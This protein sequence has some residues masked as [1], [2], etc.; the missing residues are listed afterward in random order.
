M[1]KHPLIHS[2][3]PPL[4]VTSCGANPDLRLKAAELAEILQVKAVS[5]ANT[6]IPGLLLIYTEKGL[7]IQLKE[8]KIDG[9]LTVDF[10]SGAQTYRRLRGGGIKQ[11][12]AKAVGIKPGIR[13]SVFDATAGLGGDAFCLACLGCRVTMNERSPILS[14][15]LE[16]GLQRA[17]NDPQLNAQLA[18][19]LTLQRGDSR[20]IITTTRTGIDTIYMDPMYPHRQKSALN[21]QQM[22]IIRTLVG[23]D[24][25]ADELLQTSLRYAGKRVVV[26][27]PKGAGHLADLSPS[28]CITMKNSRYDVYMIN[29]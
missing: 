2:D 25:D 24:M 6:Q 12:L 19:R 21:K 16:D 17:Y 8:K 14:A 13:P 20:T 29:H 28:H 1:V 4:A 23:D 5:T 9:M 11:A 3:L 26:K 15:L 7:Q 18:G 22:R 10:L 27:R